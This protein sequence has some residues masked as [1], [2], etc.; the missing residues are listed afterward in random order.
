MPQNKFA[1]IITATRRRRGLSQKQAALEL[2]I[3]QALLSHYENGIRECS[4]DFLVKLSDYYGVTCDYLLGHSTSKSSRT[5]SA[6]RQRTYT[7]TLET[8]LLMVERTDDEKLRLEISSYIKNCLY[9]CLKLFDGICDGLKFEGD[10]HCI[11]FAGGEAEICFTR[12]L[13]EAYNLKDM[14]IPLHES[15]LESP[16]RIINSV[17]TQLK[18]KELL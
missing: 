17:E 10:D 12:A 6:Q 3:S 2:G 11:A 1:D 14:E 5:A 13:R 9:R 4:L 16:M 8:M 15:S 18:E 7:R